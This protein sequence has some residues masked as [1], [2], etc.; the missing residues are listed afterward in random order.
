MAGTSPA[1][2][3]PW[4]DR[5]V[6]TLLPIDPQRLEIVD[7]LD[8]LPLLPD[9]DDG[10]RRHPA[11]RLG[12]EQNVP[13]RAGLVGHQV[14]QAA[15]GGAAVFR[16]RGVRMG[17]LAEMKHRYRVEIGQQPRIAEIDVAEIG[18]I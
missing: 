1:M 15:I 16:A 6:S 12:I 18:E 13:A 9:R 17:E 3:G 14:E 8:R 7:A 4:Q 10:L 5:L 11:V 2:T